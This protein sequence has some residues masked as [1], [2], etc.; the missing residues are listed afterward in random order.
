MAT[1]EILPNQIAIDRDRSPSPYL[2]IGGVA[3]SLRSQSGHEFPIP[4][5]L[6]RFTVGSCIPEIGIIVEW[7]RELAP[8]CGQ[9]VFDSGAVWKLFREQ[10]TLAF[11]FH[12]PVVGSTPYKK[13]LMDPAF[14][15]GRMLLNRALLAGF[16][17]VFPLEYP[18]DELLITNFLAQGLGVEVHG[19]GLLDAETGGHLFLGHSGA[20]KS[21]TTRLWQRYRNPEVLSDDRI[22]LRMHDGELWMYGTPWHGE[23]ALCS[24]LK[25]RISRIFVLQHGD[26]NRITPLGHAR[27]VGE[28]FSRS[29]PPFHNASAVDFTMEFLAKVVQTVPCY[30]F[31]F[32]PDSR[33]MEAVLEFHG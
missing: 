9:I 26:C 15:S 23:V 30:E 5:D 24:P 4:P 32:F 11:D 21:T 16:G 18:A 29:F 22:I 13:L 3:L 19:C 6:G 17:P 25:A 10:A 20:G 33:A 1:Q 12:S 2:N 27:A 31:S 14:S 8:S 28:L 7:V